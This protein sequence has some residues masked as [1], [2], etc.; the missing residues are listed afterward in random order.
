[1]EIDWN[2]ILIVTIAILL[3]GILLYLV[4]SRRTPSRIFVDSL[5][6]YQSKIPAKIENMKYQFMEAD[7]ILKGGGD[8]KPRFTAELNKIANELGYAFDKTASDFYSKVVYSRA[9][10]HP[11]IRWDLRGNSIE[12]LRTI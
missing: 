6:G 12:P 8:I 9:N 2:I 3:F 7:K 4:Y 1:M 10:D 5:G 11:D